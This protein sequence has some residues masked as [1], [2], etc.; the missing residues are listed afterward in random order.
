VA[1]SPAPSPARFA[2]R[3]ARLIL[4][5]LEDRTVRSTFTVLNT[6]DSGVGSLREAIDLANASV[7]VAE[8]IV[9]NYNP[10][11]GTKF[12]DST[13]DTIT[14]TSGQLTL[15]D[16]ATTTISGP[17]ANPLA[18]SGGGLSRVF[19]V[20]V[21]ASA[22]LSG[23]TITGGNADRGGGLFNEDTATLTLTDCTVSD[24]SEQTVFAGQARSI[25][26]SCDDPLPCALQRVAGDGGNE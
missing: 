15:T 14:L 25:D 19:N 1:Y 11:L 10:L 21:G 2:R 6:N 17:G 8:S 13:P 12:D 7:G 23:L 22:A 3:R 5:A 24:N 26:T 18:I 9:F 20:D 16:T 4:E